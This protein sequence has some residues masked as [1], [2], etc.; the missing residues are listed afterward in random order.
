MVR[1][2]D[3]AVRNSFHRAGY[4]L[5]FVP[6]EARVKRLVKPILDGL[7]ER[8]GDAVG[9]GLVLLLVAGLGWPAG[10]LAW[11]I[12]ALGVMGLVVVGRVRAGYVAALTSSL[13]SRGLELDELARAADVD[14]TAR[15]ALRSTLADGQKDELRR[16]LARTTPGMSLLKSLDFGYAPTAASA[17]AGGASEPEAMSVRRD[18]AAAMLLDLASPDAA[19]AAAA[20]ARWDTRDR[21]PVPLIIRL[22]AREE[23][24]REA[25]EALGRAG[26]RIA[27]TLAD[28]LA[29]ADVD[30]AI[31]RRLPRVLAHC[32]GDVAA[33]ALVAALGD[34]RFEVRYQAAAALEC[35]QAVEGARRPPRDAMWARIAAELEKSRTMWEAQRL[36]DDP[37]EELFGAPDVALAVQRRGAHSLQHVFRLLG[38]VLEPRPLALSYRAVSSDDSAFRAV[39]LEYLESVLPEDVR[40]ALWPLIGDDDTPPVSVRRRSIDEIVRELASSS[41]VPPPPPPSQQPAG[42]T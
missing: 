17:G 24:Q 20:L 35:M 30:F 1:C 23:L 41:V 13:E 28:H 10:R 37:A 15:S 26:D 33:A 34:R 39:G 42:P 3:A 18:P 4:E 27:G 36:L 9:A 21:R 31:R 11:V 12:V 5:L 6:L 22:L 29:D 32:R 2:G 14:A 19:V 25:V 16:S 38:L 40:R 7:L 8:A